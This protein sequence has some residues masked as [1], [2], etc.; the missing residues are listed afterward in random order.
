M[1]M[2][3]GWI[4]MKVAIVGTHSVGKTTLIND[5]IESNNRVKIITID[6]VA[7]N[8]IKDGYPL[9]KDASIESYLYYINMQLK[10]EI[11]TTELEYEL[12]ISD[13]SL[14]DGLAHPIVNRNLPR[15]Y[16][17]QEFIDL[18]TNILYFQKSFYD[19][20]IYLPIEFDMAPDILRPDDDVY[21]C[22]IDKEIQ[23]IL[24][25]TK[26]PFETIIDNRNE[27]C[28]QLNTLINKQMYLTHSSK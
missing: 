21:R 24:L 15:P 16:I 3:K 22:D 9:G 26:V 7:R 11:D 13:R 10:A 20:Y 27:R 5:Y 8:V 19:L 6:E 2:E 25:K 12:L 1:D 17:T 23:K 14:L 18:F 28:K 4:K